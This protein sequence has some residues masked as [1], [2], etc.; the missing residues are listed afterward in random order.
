MFTRTNSL[1]I[2]KT[3]QQICVEIYYIPQVDFQ[4][5]NIFNQSHVL[6]KG[7][8]NIIFMSWVDFQFHKIFNQSNI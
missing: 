1:N 8:L 6:Q 5:H 2:L 3:E 7:L 4:Y